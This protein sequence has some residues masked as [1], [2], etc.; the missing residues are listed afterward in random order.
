[1]I[2]AYMLAPT[3]LRVREV[4]AAHRADVERRAGEIGFV[5]RRAVEVHAEHLRVHHLR[6][7]ELRVRE[8]RALE[9]EPGKIEPR[10]ILAA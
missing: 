3:Q 9:V 8:I 2:T 4:G 6:P 5:R 10:E 7:D 1:M